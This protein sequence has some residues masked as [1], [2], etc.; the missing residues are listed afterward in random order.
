A[1][2][3]LGILL[4]LRFLHRQLDTAALV[5]VQ[6]LHLD[7]VAFIDVVGNFLDTLL[8]DLGNVQQAFGARHDFDKGTEINTTGHL[9]VVDLAHFGFGSDFLDLANGKLGGLTAFA[10][11]L[12]G[13]GIID[14]DIGTGFLAQ[15]TDGGAALADHVADLVRVDLQG[16]QRR[17]VGGQ[18]GTRRENGL[19]QFAEDME[20]AFAR[21]TQ[22]LL[23]DFLVDA[24]DLDVH[25]QRGH[26]IGGT[27]YLEVHV[28]EVIFVTEDIGDHREA[29]IVFLH[30]TH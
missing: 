7:H 14:I 28:A 12:D 22:R 2:L 11:H 15:R 30:Q 3:R 25:L 19:G 10:V 8:G 23:H 18:L 13:T 17:C 16:H 6:Y 26:A 29:T 24:L 4:Q 20:T 9:A 27:G 21:L 1:F 5:H